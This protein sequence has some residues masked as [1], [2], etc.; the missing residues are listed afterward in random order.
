MCCKATQNKTRNVDR[1]EYTETVPHF[2]VTYLNPEVFI[3]TDNNAYYYIFHFLNLYYISSQITK[4]KEKI[5]FC[6]KQTIL[7]HSGYYIK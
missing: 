2:S 3:D 1:F 5:H 7:N 4:P 6:C